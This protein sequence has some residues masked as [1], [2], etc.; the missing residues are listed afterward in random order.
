MRKI[1]KDFRE[2][3]DFARNRALALE[4]SVVVRRV[5]AGWVLPYYVADWNDIYLSDDEWRNPD[6]GPIEPYQD[7]GDGSSGLSSNCGET[8]MEGYELFHGD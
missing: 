7:S 8:L 2:V 4:T 5:D 6:E 3:A 1:W